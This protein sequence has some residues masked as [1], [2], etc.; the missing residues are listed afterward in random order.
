[1]GVAQGVDGRSVTAVGLEA[2]MN[3][4]PGEVREHVRV[5]ETVKAALIVQR[6]VGRAAGTRAEQ[7]AQ[8]ALHA[9]AAEMLGDW[10]GAPLSTGTLTAFMARGVEDLQGFLDDIHAQLITAPVAH[11]D[12]YVRRPIMLSGQRFPFA[13]RGWAAGCL[14]RGGR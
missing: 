4:G 6:I 7:P 5:I 1:M 12:D 2:V 10:I 3:G 11:F 13:C 9:S 14:T 8:A